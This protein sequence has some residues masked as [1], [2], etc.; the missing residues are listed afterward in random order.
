MKIKFSPQYGETTLNIPIT[1][2][3]KPLFRTSDFANLFNKT[4]TIY[5]D[6]PAGAIEARHF[7]RFT[8]PR[9]NVQGGYI[10][11]TDG[12]VQNI[13]NAKTVITQAVDLYKSPM[14]YSALPV[15]ER[16][17]FYTASVG[18][19]VV[20]SE[21]D[22]IVTTAQEFSALKQKYRNNGF[23]ISNVSA[24]IHGMDTDNIT[25]TSD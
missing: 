14:E 23:Q 16:E 17:N 7:D 12:T 4:V 5:N 15:D 2:E 19:F 24:Y 10:S 6:I 8:I 11:K 9:C 20:L 18:D 3:T 13:V 25:M 22:D 1:N 21:V